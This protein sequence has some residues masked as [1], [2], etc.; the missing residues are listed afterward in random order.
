VNTPQYIAIAA[1]VAVYLLWLAWA[2]YGASITN[3]GGNPFAW[4]WTREKVSDQQAIDAAKL[5]IRYW[6]QREKP[7]Y[8]NDIAAQASQIFQ[9]TL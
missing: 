7:V 5:L 2:K 8:A 3:I 1:I 9:G 6:K 4:M